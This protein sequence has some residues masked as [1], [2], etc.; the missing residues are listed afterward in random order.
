MSDRNW[1]IITCLLRDSNPKIVCSSRSLFRSA[2]NCTWLPLGISKVPVFCVTLYNRKISCKN[3]AET[4]N[5][6]V[7]KE[8]KR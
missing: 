7:K 4:N 5:S 3:V 1:T 8:I 2:A 6:E